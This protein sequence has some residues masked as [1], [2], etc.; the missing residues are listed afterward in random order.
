M[1]TIRIKTI[2]PV[3][4]HFILSISHISKKRKIKYQSQK[5]FSFFLSFFK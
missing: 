3:G 1:R 5:A 2:K 4:M